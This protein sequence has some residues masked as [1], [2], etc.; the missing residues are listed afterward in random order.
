MSC[1]SSMISSIFVP[2][3]F[4]TSAFSVEG[5]EKNFHTSSPSI[6]PLAGL[7]K[8]FLA[9]LYVLKIRVKSEQTVKQQLKKSFPYTTTPISKEI[10]T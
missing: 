7:L 10:H 1:M 8:S 6:M 9:L 4:A 2:I 5:N 3:F